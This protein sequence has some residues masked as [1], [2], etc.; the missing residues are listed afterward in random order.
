[1]LDDVYSRKKT[2]ELAKTIG[3]P[4]AKLRSI[5]S[6]DR[7]NANTIKFQLD[8][9]QWKDIKTTEEVARRVDRIEELVNSE[10]EIVYYQMLLLFRRAFMGVA[11]LSILDPQID[12]EV[13]DEYVRRL[14]DIHQKMERKQS[15]LL[16][17]D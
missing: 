17:R 9:D 7:Q 12:N 10:E 13:V 8:Q 16:M 5:A 15:I 2:K 4:E 1:M 14:E 11:K 6:V 3:D